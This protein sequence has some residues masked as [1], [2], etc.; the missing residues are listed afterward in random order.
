[1]KKSIVLQFE[2]RGKWADF[3]S[4]SSIEPGRESTIK[5]WT[6][7]APKMNKGWR[8]IERTEEVIVKA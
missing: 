1:M 4:E 6:D 2:D 7:T 5:H 3:S 8:I